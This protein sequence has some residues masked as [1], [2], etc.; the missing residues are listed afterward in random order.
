MPAASL[1]DDLR[2][3][4]A[5]VNGIRMHYAEAG[6][7]D[8]VLFL[9]GF[10]EMWY[11]WRHQ[12]EAFA[13]GYR[14]I[15]PDLRGYNETDAHP[16][17]DVGT[18]M[19][20]LR[21]LLAHLGTPRAHIVGH[22]WGGHLAWMLAIRHPEAVRTLSVCNLPH[23]ALMRK[24]LRTPAQLLRSWYI[25]AFQVPW[26]PER[27]IA[28]RGYQALARSIIRDCRPGTF[29]RDDI[30]TYLASWR[31][32]GLRGGIEWY[33]AAARHPVLP[34]GPVPVLEMPVALIWGEDDRFLGKELTR[35]TEAYASDFELHTL[36]GVSH[37]VQQEAPEAVNAI[38]RAQ[39]L[40]AAG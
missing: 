7:G 34:A 27:A 38:L 25:L 13:P 18:L 20:D 32:H 39:F 35:G 4:F 9:H 3:E 30:R 5:N 6:T 36:P 22:D 33:R 11:S 17:Y 26:L 10:P 28:A 16:P 29:T 8:P 24:G 2:H 37:W 40:K 21:A 31:E 23:P 12:L 19:D 15:A 1:P 14:V